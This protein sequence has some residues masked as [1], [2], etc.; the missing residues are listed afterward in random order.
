MGK[1]CLI[2]KSFSLNVYH[3]KFHSYIPI[4][5]VIKEIQNNYTLLYLYCEEVNIRK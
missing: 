3:D 5:Y 4:Y 1:L 2:G